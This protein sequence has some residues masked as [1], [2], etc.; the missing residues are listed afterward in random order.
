M[1]VAGHPDF[2][3]FIEGHA[4]GRILARPGLEPSVRELL[5][6]AALAV[7][8]QERQLASHVR[9]A[10]RCGASSAAV[11]NTIEAIADL[12][13]IERAESARTIAAHFSARENGA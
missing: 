13:G 11:L 5:A 3:A 2:A 7:L 9:G 12:A 8:G 10:L 4:Y 6:C 1:L